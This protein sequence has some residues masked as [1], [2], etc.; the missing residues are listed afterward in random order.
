MWETQRG[1][2]PR[3]PRDAVG[4]KLAV[5][6]KCLV[7]IPGSG[8]SLLWA[9]PLDCWL[10]PE[11]PSSSLQ[12]CLCFRPTGFLSLFPACGGRRSK[13]LFSFCAGSVSIGPSWQASPAGLSLNRGFLCI[14][15]DL[16]QEPAPLACLIDEFL[17]HL[18]F[19]QVALFTES[20]PRPPF[21]TLLGLLCGH[22]L[23]SSHRGD[24]ATWCHL[25]SDSTAWEAGKEN[26]SL[27][28][29]ARPGPLMSALK[30]P[31]KQS[32]SFSSPPSSRWV[33][34]VLGRSRPGLDATH[35]PLV[36]QCGADFCVVSGS[37]GL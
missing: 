2:G 26:S 35:E 17:L 24:G 27:S 22:A 11:S 9:L 18:G 33:T 6:S 12:Q 16:S 31:Q 30:V 25:G 37:Q 34:R 1:P 19:L 8:S 7:L 21:T 14:C 10:C 3:Q 20:T 5:P 4:P 15:W 23:R 28:N 13:G 32:R 29:P 36:R